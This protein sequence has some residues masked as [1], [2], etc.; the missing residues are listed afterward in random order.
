MLGPPCETGALGQRGT[1]VCS[2]YSVR[3]F[4]IIRDIFAFLFIIAGKLRNNTFSKN[5]DYTSFFL[6]IRFISRIRYPY[7]ARE[8]PLNIVDDRLTK[9][10]RWSTG[11]RKRKR[12]RERE[13]G[14]NRWND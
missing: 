5:F 2:A 1:R 14:R 10:K 9:V 8:I 6:I 12:K 4:L 11:E 3:S 7:I 13:R